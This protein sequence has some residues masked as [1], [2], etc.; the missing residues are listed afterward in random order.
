MRRLKAPDFVFEGRPGARRRMLAFVNDQIARAQ[1][2][3]RWRLALTFSRAMAFSGNNHTKTRFF[4]EE[5]SFHVAPFSFW[6][7]SE[8]AIV[9]RAHPSQRDLLGARIVSIGGAPVPE[10]LERVAPYIPGTRDRVIYLSPVWLRGLEVLEMIGLSGGESTEFE[11]RLADKRRVVRRLGSPAPAEPGQYPDPAQ[12]ADS[13]RQSIVPGRGPHP[14]PHVLVLRRRKSP[15]PPDSPKC[16]IGVCME[17]L[18]GA[19]TAK[20]IWHLQGEPRRF[21]EL[22]TYMTPISAKMLS[23]LFET[24]FLHVA[25]IPR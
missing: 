5:G 21:S 8:G 6:W 23:T 7:F 15:A 16:P 17:L 12:Y 22:R 11:F 20:L 3:E 10:A 4:E 2:M 19:W 24:L 25:R 18:G 1:P 13:W 9:T 14:W